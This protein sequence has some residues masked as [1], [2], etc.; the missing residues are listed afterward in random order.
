MRVQI[1]DW[2]GAPHV[3]TSSDPKLIGQW[4]AEQAAAL[5]MAD[6]TMQHCRIEIWPQ[7][8]QEHD[9]LRSGKRDHYRFTQDDLLELAQVILNASAELGERESS[10]PNR[11][12]DIVQ[13][14]KR[15]DK[16]DV[17]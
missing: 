9:M 6:C 13:S 8:H 11:K 4:F 7:T 15:L 14:P 3:I 10:T 1:I 2:V 17:R 16:L 5:M 12:A